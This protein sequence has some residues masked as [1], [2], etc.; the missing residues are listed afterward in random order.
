MTATNHGLFG[1]VIAITLQRYPVLAIV[2]APFTHFVLDAIPHFGDDKKLDLKSKKFFRILIFDC[3]LAVIST[4]IIAWF[5]KE[6]FVLVVV[7]AFLAASPDIM[8][9]YYEYIN[10]K[11]KQ[12]HLL[13]RFHSWIQWSQTPHGTYVELIWFLILFPT[14]IIASTR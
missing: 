5:W 10:P 8:W 6:I 13:P 3:S 12:K 14:L 4:L 1:A 2:I 9:I 11:L 7:C